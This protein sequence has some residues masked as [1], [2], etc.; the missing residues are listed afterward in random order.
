MLKQLYDAAEAERQSLVQRLEEITC[1]GDQKAAL[2]RQGL[3]RACD[4]R[5][6][7]TA[8]AQR[9]FDGAAT[10]SSTCVDSRSTLSPLTSSTAV[11]AVS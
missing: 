9:S 10:K 8:S 2:L 1:Q 6:D 11:V 7:I 4:V 5:P 3:G